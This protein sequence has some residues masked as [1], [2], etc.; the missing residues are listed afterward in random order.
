M[1]SQ[2]MKDAKPTNV[3]LGNPSCNH[4]PCGT[5]A[6]AHHLKMPLAEASGLVWAH[7]TSNS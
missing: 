5:I 3:Q 2:A 7:A 6:H 4:A 1:L